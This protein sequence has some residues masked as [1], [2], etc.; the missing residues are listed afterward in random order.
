MTT[1]RLCITFFKHMYNCR[2]VT[3]SVLSG[4]IARS[5]SC[6]SNLA[7]KRRTDLLLLTVC[8]YDGRLAYRLPTERLLSVFVRWLILEGIRWQQ[9]SN[10][11]RLFLVSSAYDCTCVS[12]L[13]YSYVDTT[14]INNR[15]CSILHEERTA[16]YRTHAREID[17]FSDPGRA[18]LTYLLNR[19]GVCLCPDYILH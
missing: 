11:G 5:D 13:S 3:A 10:F 7:S 6:P 9:R 15:A 16:T 2:Y 18:M 14:Y 19:S 1:A 17:Y 8:Y 12:H 4:T